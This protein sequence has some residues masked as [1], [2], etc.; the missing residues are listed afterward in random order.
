M[1]AS[2]ESFNNFVQV[3][4]R[5]R[6][7]C[8]WDH[9]QT[10]ASISHALIEEAYE[11]LESIEQNTMS[12]LKKELG[13]I[14]L[15]VVFH[16]NIAEES[17][18]FN[19]E[20]VIA[21]ITKK[22]IDRHPHIFGDTAV[23]GTEEIKVNWE[24]LKMKEGRTSVIEGVPKELPALA[25][26]HRLQD[27]AAKVGFEWKH[28]EDVWKKVEEE[29]KELHHALA[30]KNPDHVESEFGDLLFSLVNYS[31][32]IGVNPEAALRRT[33]EKFITRF[34]YIEKKL[35]EAGKDI[36]H[37]TL[38]EMDKLWEEAKNEQRR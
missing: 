21:A 6:K 17:G 28:R 4:K 12:E 16:A 11:V 29:M 37:S 34:N 36:H 1:P 13:D 10:H 35:R 38:E 25:R 24:K 32:F 20:E 3:T 27:K 14:L 2:L 30:S 23:S 9:E 7:E 22:M 18:E 33:I 15:H 19:L 8:P 5:L 31:R 26:A